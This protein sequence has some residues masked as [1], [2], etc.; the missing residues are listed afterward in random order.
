MHACVARSH[1]LVCCVCR[2]FIASR[3][4]VFERGY[5]ELY[6]LRLERCSS[7]AMAEEDLGIM[8]SDLR[9]TLAI[10][11]RHTLLRNLKKWMASR[12]LTL[13]R[14]EFKLRDF[15]SVSAVV[16]IIQSLLH[17]FHMWM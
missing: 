7:S 9:P 5:F 10:L 4:F 13:L 16:N 15:S 11:S 2:Y 8:G 6:L 3:H 14:P 17:P 12:D 1:L